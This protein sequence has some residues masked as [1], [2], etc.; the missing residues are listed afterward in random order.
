M[1]Q[2]PSLAGEFLHATCMTKK[3]K[4]GWVG[5]ITVCGGGHAQFGVRVQW[6][7]LCGICDC[8]PEKLAQSIKE[9]C[10]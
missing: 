4:G 1:G 9:D 6:E 5:R 3:K 2:V 7:C 10:V 8:G